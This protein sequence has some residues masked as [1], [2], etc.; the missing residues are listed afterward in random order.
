MLQK[1]A[2]FFW[3]IAGW[4]TFIPALLIYV[5]FAGYVMPQGAKAI[6]K[7]C[8]KKV[9]ILD[10]QFSYTPERAKAILSEY[11]FLGRCEAAKFE[12]WGDTLY[13]IAYTFLFLTIMGWVFKSLAVYDFR[14]RYIHLFPFLV[15]IADYSENVGI[16]KMLKTYPNF[17]DSLV[18]VSS[19]FT[20]L[21]WS[22]L[23]VQTFIIGVAL[24]LLTFYRITRRK[25]ISR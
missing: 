2:D 18:A 4:K 25:A 9:E 10:L 24:W 16:I 7:V 22:L 8:G 14:V 20:S 23:A 15:L 12:L 3:R 11:T 6:Q 17:S 19:L 1:I 5:V 21:K 13:P